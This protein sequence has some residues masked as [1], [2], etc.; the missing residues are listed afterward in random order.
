[1]RPCGTISKEM[2]RLGALVAKDPKQITSFF[3]N[4]SFCTMANSDKQ[5]RI[6]GFGLKPRVGFKRASLFDD[7][8]I[9]SAHAASGEHFFMTYDISVPAVS[10]SAVHSACHRWTRM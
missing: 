2:D 3:K 6:A 1:M 9:R 5:K 7:L 8:F 4:P 10:L